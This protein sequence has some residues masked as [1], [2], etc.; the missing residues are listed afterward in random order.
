MLQL[1]SVNEAADILAASPITLNHWRCTGEGPAFVKIGRL[2]R[3]DV[4]DLAA[5]IESR[6]LQSTSQVIGG[7]V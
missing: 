7:A 4:A 6:K 5:W 2:V 1:K 3:Y